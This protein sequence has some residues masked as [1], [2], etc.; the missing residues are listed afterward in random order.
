ML[1]G[2]SVEVPERRLKRGKEMDNGHVRR[3]E[4]MGPRLIS[5][6]EAG[7]ENEC[8]KGKELKYWKGN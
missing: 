7:R 3:R 2:K 4:R 8:W 5:I 6:C 1:E